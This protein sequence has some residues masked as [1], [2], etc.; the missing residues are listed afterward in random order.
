MQEGLGF[1]CPL[2]SVLVAKAGA[3]DRGPEKHKFSG[4]VNLETGW[5]KA[6]IQVG[7][8]AIQGREL[9]LAGVK[10][11]P[12]LARRVHQPAHSST[13]SRAVTC[14]ANIIQVSKVKVKLTP[15]G[16]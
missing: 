6:G 15:A 9:A 13:D 11:E 7:L 10:L 4:I 16:S 3:P 1:L 5:E 8:R 14:T 2:Q 12:K